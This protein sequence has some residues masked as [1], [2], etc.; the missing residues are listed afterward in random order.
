MTVG[1]AA[2]FPGGVVLVADGRRSY[3]LA[4]TPHIDDANK[5]TQVT[6]TVFA[7]SFGVQQATDPAVAHLVSHAK[8]S[9]DP[10]VFAA[11]VEESVLVGWSCFEQRLSPNV[12]RAHKAVR[13]ALIVGGL[14]NGTPFLASALSSFSDPVR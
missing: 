8:S 12:D 13:A 2:T 10:E 14:M 1:I 6:P 7:I 3:P 5:L 11:L 4:N 9:D